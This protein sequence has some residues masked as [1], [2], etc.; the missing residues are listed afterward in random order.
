LH[1]EVSA[2]GEPG[3]TNVDAS[4]RVIALLNGMGGASRE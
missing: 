2:K 3:P 1:G 4:I